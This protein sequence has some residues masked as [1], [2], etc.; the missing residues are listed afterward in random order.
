MVTIGGGPQRLEGVV[1]LCLEPNWVE[2]P[3]PAG[4]ILLLLS[5]KDTP[6]Q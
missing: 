2:S 6:L 3:V 5:R 1:E 4:E